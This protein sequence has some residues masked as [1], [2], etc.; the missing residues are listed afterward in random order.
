MKL[1]KLALTMLS[2]WLLMATSCQDVEPFAPSNDIRKENGT[3]LKSIGRLRF[4]SVADLSAAMQ[5][6]SVMRAFNVDGIVNPV[7][8]AKGDDF[9]DVFTPVGDL[10]QYAQVDPIIALEMKVAHN[11][12]EN[13]Q[14][15]NDMQAYEAFGYDE[16]VPETDFAKLLNV[17]GEIEVNDTVYKVSKTGT[18]FF[19]SS[20]Y[21]HFANN[22]EK[23]EVSQGSKVADKTFLMDEGIYR[24]ETFDSI[25]SAESADSDL[26]DSIPENMNAP[27]TPPLKTSYAEEV[28]WSKLPAYDADAKT[29]VGKIWQ[30]LFGRNKSYVYQISKNRRVRGKFYYYNYRVHA[31]TGALVEMQKKN[32]IGWSGT[33]AEGLT[34]NWHNIVF[35]TKYQSSVP[36]GYYLNSRPLESSQHVDYQ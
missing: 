32:W 30:S 7:D 21:D 23:Y 34:V 15:L 36:S 2:A 4:K 8:T 3:N 5:E 25:V 33:E 31:S 27:Y 29:I 22:L 26:P 14:L 9:K 12:I 20:L 35:E 16:L 10:E 13:T 19:Q 17:K 24:Y 6:V 28:P 18:Y 1:K 11:T